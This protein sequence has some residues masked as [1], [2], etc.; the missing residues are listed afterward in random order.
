MRSKVWGIVKVSIVAVLI[1]VLTLAAAGVAYRLYRHRQIASATAIDPATGVDETF[2]ARI[3]GVDQ[4][5]SIRG[6]DRANPILL[7]LHGG[8]GFAFSPLPRTF[9]HS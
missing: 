6:Q 9:L 1:L 4:W 8:P 2:F 5:I 3:G 7:I